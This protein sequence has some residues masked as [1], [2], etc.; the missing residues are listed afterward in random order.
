MTCLNKI[1]PKTFLAQVDQNNKEKNDESP[2]ALVILGKYDPTHSF[3]FA[4]HSLLLQIARTHRLAI[5]IIDDSKDLGRKINELT[6]FFHKKASLLFILSHGI[7]D[8]L[9][10]SEDIPWHQFWERRKPKYQKQD[11]DA[12]DFALLSQDAKIV[13]FSCLSGQ[14]LA[15]AVSN[16]SRRLVFAPMGY[17]CD[18]ETC[19][20]NWP[21]LD[22]KILSY[23]EKN[24]QHMGVFTPDSLSKSIISIDMLS[25][26]NANSFAEMAK[27]LKIK[28]ESGD[29]D[30]QLKLGGFY[31]CGKGNCEKSDKKA[32]E[33]ISSAAEKKHPR[34]QYMMG[35][36][37]LTG[38]GKIKQSIDQAIQWFQQSASQD[39]SP[40]LFQIGSFHY[41]GQCGFAQ[42][43]KNAWNFFYRASKKGMPEADYYLGYMYEHGRGVCL[44][45]KYAKFFYRK[46]QEMGINEAKSQLA[47]LLFQEEQ[48]LLNN[49]YLLNKIYI[50]IIELLEQIREIYWRKINQ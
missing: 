31:L 12:S 3:G 6:T 21:N 34:A 30:A 44:S 1:L 17:I 36:Y 39:F 35:C 8:W 43:D 49:Y 22:I 5:A 2:I 50:F 42:S 7:A 29:A 4:T 18:T 24:Q 25:K 38:Q 41:N 16:V 13:L 27:Y 33:L 48:F 45:L 19:L 26:A 23:N 20:Q 47:N 10:F 9:K 28:A 40:A 15:Q 32:L 11:I 14:K 37:Y 46:A